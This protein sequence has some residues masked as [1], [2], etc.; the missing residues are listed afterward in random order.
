MN[1]GLFSSDVSKVPPA[2]PCCR[3]D[4]KTYV[5]WYAR[6][7]VRVPHSEE[8]QGI[9]RA[10]TPRLNGSWKCEKNKLHFWV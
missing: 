1:F 4:G 7:K 9:F 2:S 10:I 5:M 3:D 8:S 6:E